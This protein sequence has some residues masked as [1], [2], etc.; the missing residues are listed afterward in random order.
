MHDFTL[1]FNQ[2]TFDAIGIALNILAWLV[3]GFAILSVIA[4]AK[5][6]VSDLSERPKGKYNE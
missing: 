5:G 6:A 1:W 4:L 2:F 3:M